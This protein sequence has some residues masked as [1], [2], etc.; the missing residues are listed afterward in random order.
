MNDDDNLF[1]LDTR[2]RA[3]LTP[4][5]EAARRVVMRAL[6][7][8]DEKP[9]RQQRLRVALLT[10]AVV[11]LLVVTGWQW[12][13][14]ASRAMPPSLAITSD[15]SM[16]VVESEDGRRWIVGPSPTRS[17]AGSYVI[18]FGGTEKPQ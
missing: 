12:R 17:T 18:V 5:T 10:A 14:G 6:A 2:V 16:L 15:G 4:E 3:A 9:R 13:R 7:D 11:A 8:G 1:D